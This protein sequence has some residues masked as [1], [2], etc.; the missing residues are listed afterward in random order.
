MTWNLSEKPHPPTSIR[1]SQKMTFFMRRYLSIGQKL[2][3]LVSPTDK[4]KEFYFHLFLVSKKD[5]SFHPVINL[6]PLNQ[7]IHVRHFKMETLRTVIRFV[8]PGDWQVFIDLKDGSVHIS[9][10]PSNRTKRVPTLCI[11]RSF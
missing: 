8:K 11:Q 6:K 10:R 1:E 2:I 3:K 9:I 4:H 7:Y 5:G